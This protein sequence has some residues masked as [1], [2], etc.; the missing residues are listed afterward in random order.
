[1]DWDKIEQ[2]LNIVGKSIP[3]GTKL[4]GITNAALTELAKHNEDSV[5]KPE[6]APVPRRKAPQE[7]E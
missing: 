3:H 4:Q 5:P 7:V 6:V 1:M 2:L